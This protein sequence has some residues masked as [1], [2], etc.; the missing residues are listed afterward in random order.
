M[1]DGFQNRFLLVNDGKSIVL[2]SLSLKQVY[3]DS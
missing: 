3:E 2:V 1:H